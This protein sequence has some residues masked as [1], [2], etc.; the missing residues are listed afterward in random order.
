MRNEILY[1]W[2]AGIVDGEGSIFLEKAKNRKQYR[3]SVTVVNT[4]YRILLRLKDILGGGILLAKRRKVRP[5]RLTCWSWYS[6]GKS[7]VDVLEKIIPYLV[8]KREKAEIV[9]LYART[10]GIKPIDNAYRYNLVR[11]FKKITIK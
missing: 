2:C 10:V 5:N 9:L 4:D 8:S 3:P 7:A 6:K 1:A 11:K